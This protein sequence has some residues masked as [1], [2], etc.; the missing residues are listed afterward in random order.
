MKVLIVA[1][2]TPFQQSAANVLK[3]QIAY[4]NA[5]LNVEIVEPTWSV[6][7]PKLVDDTLLL[8]PFCD[9]N[10]DLATLPA[11]GSIDGLT[12]VGRPMQPE[13]HPRLNAYYRQDSDI[14]SDIAGITA[15][16]MSDIVYVDANALR[17][18][19]FTVYDNDPFK[20]I[21]SA[22]G[23]SG[24]LSNEIAFMVEHE[25]H[26]YRHPSELRV[27]RGLYNDAMIRCFQSRY[28][29]TF[30]TDV[31]NF[32]K[33]F[34]LKAYRDFSLMIDGVDPTYAAWLDQVV[35][36]QKVTRF[37][38]AVAKEIGIE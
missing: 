11:I 23:G 22:P 30:E 5:S 12:Y 35:S 8:G 18:G 7:E 4:H 31:N 29:S 25:L 9:V 33:Q 10:G 32:T 21:A 26:E 13:V 14:M 36:N 38:D 27:G 16:Y 28:K 1:D 3:E 17:D 15:Y 20:T 24:T 6:V 34:H 37:Q 2:S 19:G